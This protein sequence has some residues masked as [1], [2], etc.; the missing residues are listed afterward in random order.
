MD[1]SRAERFR[2]REYAVVR[3]C[4]LLHESFCNPKRRYAYIELSPAVKICQSNDITPAGRGG[5]RHW[6]D[7]V[8]LNQYRVQNRANRRENLDFY[9]VGSK[10]GFGLMQVLVSRLNIHVSPAHAS[11]VH[12]H[13]FSARSLV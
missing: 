4:T 8:Q 5:F 2:C 11:F 10:K 13:A 7:D 12:F 9:I 3:S 6:R 1:I